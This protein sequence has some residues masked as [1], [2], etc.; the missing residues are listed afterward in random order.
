MSEFFVITVLIFLNMIMLYLGYLAIKNK[1]YLM[2]FIPFTM[3]LGSVNLTAYGL[4]FLFVNHRLIFTEGFCELA[5]QIYTF[6]SMSYNYN[7]FHNYLYCHKFSNISYRTNFWNRYTSYWFYWIGGIY[8]RN[9][10]F[11]TN[12]P[13]LV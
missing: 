7:E 12:F 5:E 1:A 4:N 9:N 8:I 6:S 2:S 3:F 13:Q 11:N 10:G